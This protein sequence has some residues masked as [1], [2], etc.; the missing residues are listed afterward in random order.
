M[1]VV[2]R[3]DFPQPRGNWI[4]AYAG[5]TGFASGGTWSQQGRIILRGQRPEIFIF[6]GQYTKCRFSW[7]LDLGKSAGR[8]GVTDARIDD[9]GADRLDDPEASRPHFARLLELRDAMASRF[10]VELPDLSM[11]M[12]GDYE[13]AAEEGATLVRVGTALFS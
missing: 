6:W 12:S 2:A 8:A 7:A 10:G 4:P 1:R 13:V 3:S 5:M 11:G 9:G